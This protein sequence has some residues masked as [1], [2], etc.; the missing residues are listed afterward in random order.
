MSAKA[1][2]Q[3]FDELFL[4]FE[5]VPL[6]FEAA[7]GQFLLQLGDC[8][9]GG[10]QGILIRGLCRRVLGACLRSHLRQA[11]Q[12]SNTESQTLSEPWA[13]HHL[14]RE[15]SSWTSLNLTVTL[16]CGPNSGCVKDE[17]GV[18][19]SCAAKP[20]RRPGLPASCR[21]S[22]TTGCSK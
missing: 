8:Q 10:V 15:Q 7:L 2:L 21:N 5:R 19:V 20:K 4:A 22:Q 11:K 3:A 18:R 12:S 13:R 16:E 1:C 6:G 9:G 14:P 17:K